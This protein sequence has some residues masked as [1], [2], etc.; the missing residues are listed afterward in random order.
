MESPRKSHGNPATPG[1]RSALSFR[2]VRTILIAYVAVTRVKIL[3]RTRMGCAMPRRFLLLAVLCCTL[4]SAPQETNFGPFLVRIAEAGSDLSSKGITSTDCILV[5]PDGHFHLER[6][7]QRLPETKATTQVFESS[8]AAVQLQSLRSIIDSQ[9]IKDLPTYAQPTF[10]MTVTWF[11]I[12]DVKI[13]RQS[14]IQRVGY[15]T[16]LGGTRDT[17]PNVM[18]EEIKNTWRTSAAALQPLVEWFHSIKNSKLE[19]LPEAE[20][21]FCLAAAESG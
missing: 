7:T 3:L 11:G 8:L 2:T 14:E 6:R 20:I 10:P 15:F 17:S 13:A 21:N 5:L 9:T 4:S 19:P 1:R 12:L 16:W 18:P